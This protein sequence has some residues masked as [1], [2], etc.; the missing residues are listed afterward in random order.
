MNNLIV[1]E[2]QEFLIWI[3]CKSSSQYYDYLIKNY[4]GKEIIKLY[5]YNTY[6]KGRNRECFVI[7]KTA[8]CWRL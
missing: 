5:E 1:Q 4:K 8:I 7:Q 6:E 2:I 3:N